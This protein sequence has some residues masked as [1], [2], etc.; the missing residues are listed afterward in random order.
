MMMFDECKISSFVHVHFTDKFDV[1]F[2]EFVF[3]KIVIVI[4]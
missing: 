1:M 4:A 3:C 2:V